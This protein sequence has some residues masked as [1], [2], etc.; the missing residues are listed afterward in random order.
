MDD[1][2]TQIMRG[3][4]S[5]AKARNVSN[6]EQT[7]FEIGKLSAYVGNTIWDLTNEEIGKACDRLKT[8]GSL[9][10]CFNVVKG[11]HNKQEAK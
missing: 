3:I 8:F 10:H 1:E 2:I 4:E 5:Q 9:L 11:D 7:R 6:I